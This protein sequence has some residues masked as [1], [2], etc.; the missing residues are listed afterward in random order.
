VLGLEC[1]VVDYAPNLRQQGHCHHHASM[2]LVLRGSLEED[3]AH[4]NLRA[5]ALI[6]IA[7]TAGT[8]HSSVYGPKGC[9]TLQI[10]FG[11]EFEIGIA[12]TRGLPSGRYA[13][14]PTVA[15]LLG[16][17][18]ELGDKSGSATTLAFYEVLAA[19]STEH[20]AYGSP[21]RW[22][23]RTKEK[24]DESAP[25]AHWTLAE[26]GR[27]AGVHPVHLTKQFRQHFGI[28]IRAYLKQRR[29]HAAANAITE[30][31]V[32]ASEIAY[33][34]GYAD[35]AHLCRDFRNGT[36]TTVLGYRRMLA[37]LETLSAMPIGTPG[38]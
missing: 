21:P 13:G 34:F 11:P 28:T 38:D 3:L 22:L 17:L 26:L 2:T 36:R 18:G 23:R 32:S 16:F 14:G 9:R 24:I 37:R 5:A 1:V 33:R 4:T 35:R 15:A 20:I 30:R 25:I 29:L 12:R 10:N 31:G 8:C 7:K 19:L 6:A 27:E